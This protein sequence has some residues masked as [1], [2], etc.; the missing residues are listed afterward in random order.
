MILPTAFGTT[1]G[2][3]PLVLALMAVLA[4]GVAAWPS[5]RPSRLPAPALVAGWL[6]HAVLLVLDIGGWG[7]GEPGA[8]LGFRPGALAHCLAG[9]GRP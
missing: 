8:R 4:Y 3:A 9:A 6:L 2:L 7:R 5:R 1:L